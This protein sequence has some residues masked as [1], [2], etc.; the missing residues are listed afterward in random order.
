MTATLNAVSAP[1]LHFVERVRDPGVDGIKYTLHEP[2]A[3]GSSWS[4]VDG[5]HGVEDALRRL[6]LNLRISGKQVLS[7]R[8]CCLSGN[9]QHECAGLAVL[10]YVSG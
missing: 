8:V 5:D 3:L 1:V 6:G 9:T 2:F 7:R 4:S 10:Q